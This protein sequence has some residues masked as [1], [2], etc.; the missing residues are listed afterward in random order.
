MAQAAPAWIRRL[1]LTYPTYAKKLGALSVERLERGA[2]RIE[3][4]NHF[5]RNKAVGAARDV[6][7]DQFV[8]L[9]DRRLG[10]ENDIRI[11]QPDVVGGYRATGV[12]SSAQI[13]HR[14]HE[15]PIRT[16]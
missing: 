13:E 5:A 2:S 11:V 16:A 8:D 14:G 12:Q 9:L 3:V 15:T 6:L 4:P 7:L 10:H 1:A